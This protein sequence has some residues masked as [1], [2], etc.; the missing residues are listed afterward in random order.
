MMGSFLLPVQAKTDKFGTWIEFEF[1][2]EFLKRFAFSI[3]PEFRFQDQLH[4]DEYM[5]QGKLSYEPFSFLTM[6]G[7]YR[8]R[9]EVKKKDNHRLSRIAFDVQASRDISRFKASVRMRYTNSK[10]S[11]EDEAG[12]YL[13]PRLKL[14]YDIQGNKITPFAAYEFFHNITEKELHK[15]R[16][17]VGFTRNI[18]DF[19]RIGLYYRLHNYFTDKESIHILGIE[20]RLKF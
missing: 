8:L 1:E 18:A 10:D 11:E 4:L 12:S 3:A 2:K 5:V 20:Y 9:T 6:A 14:E 7:S 15:Y 16:F 17:D 13:R 19:H